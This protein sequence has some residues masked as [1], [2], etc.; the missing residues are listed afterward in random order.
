MQKNEGLQQKG[1]SQSQKH[2]GGIRKSQENEAASES[3]P[4]H[5]TEYSHPPAERLPQ[6]LHVCPTLSQKQI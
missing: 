2:D 1:W 4:Q 5:H 3:A 6:S